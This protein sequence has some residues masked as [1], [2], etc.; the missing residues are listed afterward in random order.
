MCDLHTSR[1]ELLVHG[2]EA[3][4]FAHATGC[5]ECQTTL[6]AERAYP[7]GCQRPLLGYR[8]Q[9]HLDALLLGDGVQPELRA[10]LDDCPACRIEVAEGRDALA[11]LEPPNPR[12]GWTCAHCGEEVAREATASCATCSTPHHAPCFD[13]HG[14]CALPGCAD[15]RYVR[16]LPERR[17]G[18]PRWLLGGLI[19]LVVSAG[20]DSGSA[21][22][23]PVVVKRLRALLPQPTLARAG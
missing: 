12:L 2:Q 18:L 3:V 20:L 17:S 4:V 10:H 14:R 9:L 6:L 15:R 11:E 19:G 13:Q 22:A 8:L 5:P 23:R 16:A 7:P 21:D 1:Q